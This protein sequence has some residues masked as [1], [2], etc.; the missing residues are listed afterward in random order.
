M[1]KWHL[2]I[3]P[4]ERFDLIVDFSKVPL[5]TEVMLRNDANE[6]YPD[7][8]APQVT[9][10]LKINVATPVPANDPDTSVNPANL[11]LKSVAR[12]AKTAGLPAR[13][14]SPRRPWTWRPTRRWRCS[15]TA[16][17]STTR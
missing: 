5:G 16:T 8:D 1:K 13:P 3:A 9:D 4:G 6:P 7:G 12:L 11:R 2:T 14:W 10:M 15:S 17:T